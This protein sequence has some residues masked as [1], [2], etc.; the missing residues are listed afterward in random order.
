M[1]FLPSYA[2][3]TTGLFC[4]NQHSHAK[5]RP[6]KWAPMW[7]RESRKSGEMQIGFVAN[8]PPL[9]SKFKGLA[10]RLSGWNGGTSKPQK[11]VG[12]RNHTSCSLSLHSVENCSVKR[13]WSNLRQRNWKWS[14]G[15][16]SFGHH[17][18][19][20]HFQYFKYFLFQNDVSSQKHH[21]GF[22]AAKLRITCCC[23]NVIIVKFKE[24]CHPSLLAIKCHSLQY[25][26]SKVIG[27]SSTWR[28]ENSFMCLKL[29]KTINVLVAMPPPKAC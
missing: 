29:D 17:A 13:V 2:L 28:K 19:G 15:S 4:Q 10:T 18:Q 12:P 7:P 23:E 3:T 8:Q 1:T 14:C 5:E 21:V 20:L 22:L 11:R 26:N 6:Q 27:F 25:P 9:G 16:Q 24:K